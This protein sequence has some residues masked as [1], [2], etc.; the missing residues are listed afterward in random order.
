M[1]NEGSFHSEGCSSPYSP[2]KAIK[3]TIELYSCE[4]D[5]QPDRMD[6]PREFM[7]LCLIHV[8]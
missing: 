7:A 3:S 2:G 6:D 8:D 1:I 4:G 5:Q